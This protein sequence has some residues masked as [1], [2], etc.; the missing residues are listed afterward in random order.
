MG[1]A[2]ADDPG[3]HPPLRP[4]AAV[5]PHPSRTAR[6][7]IRVYA[8]AL[9]AQGAW[10]AGQPDRARS[11]PAPP[12]G[13]SVLGAFRAATAGS[14]SSSAPTPTT[15]SPCRS[16]SPG[17]APATPTP[18]RSASPPAPARATRTSAPP[19]LAAAAA[20]TTR[21][22]APSAFAAAALRAPGCTPALGAPERRLLAETPL[23]VVTHAAAARPDPFCLFPNPTAGADRAHN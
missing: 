13:A 15:S 14:R 8:L 17:T 3:A 4:A 20:D 2:V 6:T 11:P 18:G 22:A 16:S 12:A 7:C 1:A 5:A 21:L 10:R 23:A 9:S 19:R